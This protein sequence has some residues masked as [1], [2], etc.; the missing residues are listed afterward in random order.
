MFNL[1]IAVISQT[2]EQFEEKKRIIDTEQM[3]DILRDHNKF[4][5]FFVRRAKEKASAIMFKKKKKKNNMF[6]NKKSEFSHILKLV[7]VEDEDVNILVDK[8]K[9][10]VVTGN[11]K[12]RGDLERIE[13]RVEKLEDGIEEILLFLKDIKR[14]GKL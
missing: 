1:L 6:G 10:E 8:V 14:G 13:N 7:N 3:I 12:V 2:F 4:I 5:T 11:M 9:E